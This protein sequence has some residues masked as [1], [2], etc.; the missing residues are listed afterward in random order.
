M[1]VLSDAMVPGAAPFEIV[2][3][4]ASVPHNA[5]RRQMDQRATKETELI[6]GFCSVGQ[7]TIA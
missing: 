5:R 2:F 4:V 1:F 3:A 7:V 6:V